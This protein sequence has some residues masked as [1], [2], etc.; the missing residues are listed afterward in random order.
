MTCY[1]LIIYVKIPIELYSVEKRRLNVMN[2]LQNCSRMLDK[3]CSP[4]EEE[5]NSAIGVEAYKAWS[6]MRQ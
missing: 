6:I 5:I 3:D 2:I 4:C 1:C